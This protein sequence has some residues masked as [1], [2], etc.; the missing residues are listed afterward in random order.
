MG[1][2]KGIGGGTDEPLVTVDFLDQ[3]ADQGFSV[4]I[5]FVFCLDLGQDL[6]DMEGFAG[7]VEY[8]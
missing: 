3:G 7:L 5:H 1:R 8:V 6:R 2:L 4:Q